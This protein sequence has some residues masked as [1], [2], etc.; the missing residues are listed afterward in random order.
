MVT[1]RPDIR[2]FVPGEDRTYRCRRCGMRVFARPEDRR[3]GY[4]FDCYDP[5]QSSNRYAL[6]W[7]RSS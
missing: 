2:A 7:A 6:S 3:S 5:L 4:C 1:L